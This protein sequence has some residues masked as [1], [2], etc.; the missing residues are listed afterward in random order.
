MFLLGDGEGYAPLH[1]ADFD[2]PDALLPV[3]VSLFQAL[4]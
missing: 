4:I 1:S 3:A 2:F